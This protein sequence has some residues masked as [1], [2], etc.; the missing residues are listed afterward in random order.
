MTDK[1]ITNAGYRMLELLKELAK[2]PLSPSELLNIIEEKTDNCYRKELVNKYLNTLKIMNISIGKIRDKYCL[3]KSFDTID[4][5]KTDISML[6]FLK[7]YVNKLQCPA[8]K[9]ELQEALQIIE[10]NFSDSTYELLQ[11][12]AIKAYKPYCEIILDDDNAKTFEKYCAEKFKLEIKYRE[13]K[14]TSYICKI[15]PL[16]I[17]Y[18]KGSVVLLAY[19]F[20]TN[21]YK[22][23]LITNIIDSR[24][25]PQISM[26]YSP[27]SV[28]FKLKNR[29]AQA[30]R[31][32]E[33]E[34]VIEYGR[35]YIIVSNNLEDKNLLIKRLIRYY[36]SCEILYPTAIKKQMLKLLDEMEQIYAEHKS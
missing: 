19:C 24:Q 31:L 6:K 9:D 11:K 13:S 18:K 7:K 20:D 32:K 8:Y 30:Y 22:E 36:D 14:D 16:K 5:D 34:S 27:S 1:K 12:K 4:F 33:G 3:E 15:A 10:Q 25:L 2:K 26:P 35:D 17:F 28:T 29:L 21:S 23:F